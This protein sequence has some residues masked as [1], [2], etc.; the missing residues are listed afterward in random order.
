MKALKYLISLWI[1]ILVYSLAS[2][3]SGAMGLS[4]YTQLR[5]E[6][7]RQLVNLDTLNRIN[8][9]LEGG[10]D[11]LLYDSDLIAAHARELGYGTESERFIRIVGLS[12]TRKQNLSPGETLYA[13]Q[14]EYMTERKIGLLSLAAG[15]GTLLLLCIAEFIGKR[16]IGPL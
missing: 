16:P 8:T 15:V 1:G 9:E 7:D 2:L 14:P 6:R 5:E 12:G 3:S 10:K 11:A 13:R 4:A